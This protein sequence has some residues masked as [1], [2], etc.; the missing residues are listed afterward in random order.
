MLSSQTS[1]SQLTLCTCTQPHAQEILTS[2][3]LRDGGADAQEADIEMAAGRIAMRMHARETLKTALQS[4]WPVH[5]LSVN[6]SAALIK[7]ALAGLPCRLA[8]EDDSS[9]GAGEEGAYQG[10]IIH[11]N[12]LEMQ[13]GMSTGVSHSFVFQCRAC[14]AH[15]IRQACNGEWRCARHY[16][17]LSRLHMPAGNVLANI[18]GPMDKGNVIEDVLLSMA[19]ASGDG[20]APAVYVGDSIGDLAALLAAHVPIVLGGNAMLRHALN[21]FGCTL[22][23]LTAHADLLSGGHPAGARTRTLLF[24]VYACST[25][26]RARPLTYRQ[27]QHYGE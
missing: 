12:S 5:V 15:G 19:A 13:L 16:R 4:G 1:Y 20:S 23:T 14:A 2:S 10:V 27:E 8:S 11:A 24:A 9:E 18:Q 26:F 7:A 3:L 6:W 17:L 21:T 25:L 22:H